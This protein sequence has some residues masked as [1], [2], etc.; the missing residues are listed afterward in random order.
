M[1]RSWAPGRVRGAPGRARA[2]GTRGDGAP[3]RALPR[4][5][6][7]ALRVAWARQGEGEGTREMGRS[8][9]GHAQE[10]HTPHGDK[11]RGEGS[12]NKGSVTT[13]ARA[14]TRSGAAGGP[15]WHV[16]FTRASYRSGSRM[17]RPAAS[18]F[19]GSAGLG[20]CHTT[21]TAICVA[22]T[23]PPPTHPTPPHPTP[24]HL[25]SLTP[26]TSCPRG[27]VCVYGVRMVSRSCGWRSIGVQ[28]RVALGGRTRLTV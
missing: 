9:Q 16:P 23:S 19:R 28:P 26:N 3:A 1:A 24:P 21:A 20:Y 27:S 14:G 5:W 22:R 2:P 10:T 7:R 12:N 13:G 4:T 18:P 8:Q 15:R 17:R 11:G 25:T 6:P